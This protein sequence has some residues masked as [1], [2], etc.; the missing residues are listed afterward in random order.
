MLRR[1]PTSYYFYFFLLIDLFHL[2]FSIFLFHSTFR[3]K[4]KVDKRDRKKRWAWS[5]TNRHYIYFAFTWGKCR[6]L[7]EMDT[8][9]LWLLSLRAIESEKM[10]AHFSFH[11]VPYYI[12]WEITRSKREAPPKKQANF[13][14]LKRDHKTRGAM[15]SVHN[16]IFYFSSHLMSLGAHTQTHIP[17]F[18]IFFTSSKKSFCSVRKTLLYNKP[19]YY[20]T[21][22]L[23]VCLSKALRILFLLFVLIPKFSTSL[24]FPF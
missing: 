8:L 22:Y 12:L 20:R 21:T 5:F 7:K 24:W 11:P 19:Q 13:Y 6:C 17:I 10:Q 2:N 14:F 16:S 4:V 15:E 3:Y 9:L 23:C 1:Q 18:F